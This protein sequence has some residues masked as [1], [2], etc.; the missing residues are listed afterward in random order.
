[1][2]KVVVSSDIC[3]LILSDLRDYVRATRCRDNPITLLPVMIEEG[4]FD[5]E[6]KELEW[7]IGA[8]LESKKILEVGCGYGMIVAHGRLNRG[9]DI[10]GVEPSKKQFEGRYEVAAQLLSE[11]GLDSDYIRCGTGEDIPFPNETFDV[12]FSFQVLEH[13]DDPA[14]VLRE[15]ARVLKKGG[16][17]Y[18]NVP[19]YNTFF[20][21]HYCVPWLPGMGKRLGRVYLRLLKR[22]PQ[23]LDHLN[24]LTRGWLEK[25]FY[26]IPELEVMTDYGV[27]E[28]AKG[29]QGFSFEEGED[30]N[31]PQFKRLVRLA[32]GLGLLWLIRRLGS[33]FHWQDTLRVVARKKNV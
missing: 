22:D 15:S 32:Q 8:T 30:Y 20:E 12:V 7:Q 33:R 2:S 1:M 23:F 9:L 13:V 25:I 14:Q 5:S 11:N 6:L 29:Y 16:L 17:L 4:R 24:F 3:E 10:Y 18:V 21:G 27:G 31:H 19:N 26:G 28:W